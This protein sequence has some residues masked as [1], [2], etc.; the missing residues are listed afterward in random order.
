MPGIDVVFIGVNDLA[1]NSGHILE[2]DHPEVRALVDRAFSRAK[3]ADKKVGTVPTP[4][5]NFASLVQAGF[6]L[7]LPVSDLAMLRDTAIRELAAL[8]QAIR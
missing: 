1:A 6:D 2:L 5:R 8:R 4:N 7:V 3:A